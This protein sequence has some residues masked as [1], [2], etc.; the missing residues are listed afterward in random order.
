MF[1]GLSDDVQYMKTLLYSGRVDG[2]NMSTGQQTR[3]QLKPRICIDIHQVVCYM[4][5]PEFPRNRTIG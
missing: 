3:T 1:S 2:S 4:E 5:Q